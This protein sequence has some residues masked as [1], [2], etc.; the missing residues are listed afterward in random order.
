[1][2]QGLA[3]PAAELGVVRVFALDG[4]DPALAAILPPHPVDGGHLAPLLGLARIDDEDVERIALRD[5]GEMA[6][7][8]L[9]AIGHDIRA[10]D[11]EPA[12]ARLDEIHS[13][14]FG[15]QA[16]QL[17]PAPG[18][19]FLGAFRRNDAPPAPLSLPA[20]ERGE[21]LPPPPAAAAP[22]ARK[23]WAMAALFLALLLLGLALFAGLRG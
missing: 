5:L 18:L 19:R 11:L 12:R 8:D 20:A 22:P 23:G 3:V 6:L 9:L 17:A 2:T 7:S 14:A 13:R 21:A 1:M 15:G 16:A 4:A 10:E